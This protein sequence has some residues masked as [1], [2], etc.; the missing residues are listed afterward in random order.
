M[1]IRTLTR[2][3]TTPP[4]AHFGFSVGAA[5]I[6]PPEG[7]GDVD[8]LVGRRVKVRTLGLN[9]HGVLV[10]CVSKNDLLRLVQRVPSR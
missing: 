3:E 4:A 10:A 9:L 7:V 6:G 2:S 5:S 1:P 8:T